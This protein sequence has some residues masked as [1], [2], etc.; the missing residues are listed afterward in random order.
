M[1][2]AGARTQALAH[3]SECPNCA[4]RLEAEQRLTADLRELI[5]ATKDLT[6]SATVWESLSAGFD[7][8]G[9]AQV[10]TGR[11][12][13]VYAASAIAAV[14]LLMFALLPVVRRHRQP[15]NV[16]ASNPTNSTAVR[17]VQT[18]KET[19]T[20]RG[21]DDL[22]V[23]VKQKPQVISHRHLPEPQTS[24]P[25]V[26]QPKEIATDFIPLTYGDPNVGSDAQMVRVELPRSAM[27]SFGLPVNM[28]RADQRVKADVL[29][30]SDGLA[31]AI[32]FVQ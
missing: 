29:L 32:R 26:T 8:R 3:A 7:A 27:A 17:A 10:T 18:T 19:A 6:A 4:G 16:E 31:R 28:D 20:G 23:N 14:L 9:V 25:Q 12:R 11:R 24:A 30:G 5:S 2:D 21:Q 15:A 1:M 22:A 13:W